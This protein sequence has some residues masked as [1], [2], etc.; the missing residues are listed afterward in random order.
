[1]LYNSH[2]FEKKNPVSRNILQLIILNYIIQR[3]GKNDF[4]LSD[5]ESVKSQ[6]KKKNWFL[7]LI[8]KYRWSEWSIEENANL[9]EAFI[10]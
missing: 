7:M 5:E 9:H 3:K 10:D 6:G 1:M 2:M 4:E 8:F